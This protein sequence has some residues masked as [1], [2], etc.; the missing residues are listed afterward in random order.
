MNQEYKAKEICFH[1]LMFTIL[2]RRTEVNRTVHVFF[3]YV[4]HEV[5]PAVAL[6][7]FSLPLFALA[8]L[9]RE[10]ED[11]RSKAVVT[12]ATAVKGIQKNQ[13]DTC[14]STAQLRQKKS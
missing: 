7:N 6:N 9:T 4:L 12:N 2:L 13:R 14:R 10:K 1:C 8:S 11:K 5:K 3:L